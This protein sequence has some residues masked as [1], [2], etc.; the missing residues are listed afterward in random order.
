MQVLIYNG[1]DRTKIPN[2]EKIICFLKNDDLRSANVKKIGVNLYRARLNKSDRLLF[3]IYKTNQHTYALILEYI[4]NHAYEKSRFLR[5]GVKIDEKRIPTIEKIDPTTIE[6]LPHLDQTTSR[7]HLLHKPITFDAAQQ[8]IYSLPVPMIIIGTAGSGKTLLLLEKMKRFRGK[9]LYITQSA[10]LA[11]HSQNLYFSH[12]FIE[13]KQSVSFLSYQDFLD[14]IAVQAGKAMGFSDFKVWFVKHQNSTPVQDIQA[15]YEEFQGVITGF[16]VEKAYLSREEYLALG[17]K[18]S[19]FIDSHRNN[20]YDLFVRYLTYLQ[21]HDRYNYNLVSFDY[22]TLRKKSNDYSYDYSYDYIV[23]DEVQDLSPIQLHLILSCLSHAS[24]FLLCGDS[25]QIVYPNFFSWTRIKSLFFQEGTFNAGSLTQIL[26]TNYRNSICVIE[27]ANKLLRLKNWRFG[28]IDKESH[29]EMKT[30]GVE[31]G[32]TAFFPG[33]EQTL[34]SI[35]DKTYTSK[36]FAVI[37]LYDELKSVAAKYFKTPLIFSVQ[38]C[39]GLEYENVILFNMVSSANQSF[40]DICS[41]ITRD[42]LNNPM[43]YAR[44]KDKTDKSLEKYKFFINALFVATTRAQLNL[45]WVEESIDH[46]LLRLLSDPKVKHSTADINQQV[47]STEEWQQEAS[48]LDKQGKSEQADLIR[49]NILQQQLPP[50]KVIAGKEIDPLFDSALQRG[51]KKAKLF[52]FEYTLIHEDHQAR[53]ALITIGFSPALSPEEGMERLLKKYFMMYQQNQLDAIKRQINKYGV[54]FRNPFNQTPLM[55]GAWLGKSQ[56]IQLALELDAD[57]FLANNK[58]F[59]AF[60]IAL[61]QACLH[62]SYASEKL[63]AV[64]SLLKPETLSL[65]VDNKLYKLE[66]Y[67]AEFFLINLMIALF[68]RILPENML[69]ANGAFSANNL[70]KAIEHWPPS[71]LSKDF[72]NPDYISQVLSQ[73]QISQQPTQTAT[74]HSPFF[75][76]VSAGHYLL[77][78]EMMLEAEGGWFYVYDILLFDDLAMSHHDGHSTLPSDSLYEALLREKVESYKQALGIRSLSEN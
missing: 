41:G 65:R 47:S 40:N 62:H 11:N 37:V 44:N 51:D 12:K 39:K 17:V 71:I 48:E 30:S 25:N 8:Q 14:S 60:Q 21:Q 6:S 7:F 54:N 42:I 24:H 57:P 16:N 18:E 61:E 64:Y 63:E 19:I 68:Y 3:S 67:Q 43:R 56:V 73:H 33:D 4:K 70:V 52:L 23:V 45:F 38:E 27:M 15:L 10:Y 31:R 20:V 2:F 46:P 55:I 78:P 69:L 5:R 58:G 1:I 35:N 9:V 74:P 72:Y 26:N 49:Q 75:I 13:K 77:N 29:Y 76:E 66:H 32:K 50:W 59:N 36:N 34:Q 53:N 22:L 28:S